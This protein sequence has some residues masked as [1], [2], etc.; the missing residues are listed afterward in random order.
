[1]FCSSLTEIYW[2][3]ESWKCDRIIQFWV[4]FAILVF[5]GLFG[6]IGMIIG[7]PV[8]AVIYDIVKKLVHRGLHRNGQDALLAEYE[9]Q[10]TNQE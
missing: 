3:R 1:M 2:D 10:F 5:G 9:A 7:V 4:L 8:F 6:F